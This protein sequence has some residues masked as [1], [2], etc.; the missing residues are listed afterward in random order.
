LSV[1]SAQVKAGQ[2]KKCFGCSDNS[3]PHSKR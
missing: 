3:C 2:S 1:F